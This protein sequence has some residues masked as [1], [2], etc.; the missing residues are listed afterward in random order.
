MTSG[1]HPMQLRSCS[2]PGCSLRL[3]CQ[4]CAAPLSS[5]MA[6]HNQLLFIVQAYYASHDS[7]GGCMNP[8]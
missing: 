5:N 1:W 2:Q 7:L 8:G 4:V 3:L 6:A